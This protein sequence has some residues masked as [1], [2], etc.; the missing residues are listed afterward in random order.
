M[1]KPAAKP[2]PR[3]S[4][5]RAD[6]PSR[7]PPPR[8][9]STAAA[10]GG[11]TC[12]CGPSSQ[13][14]LPARQEVPGSRPPWRISAPRAPISASTPVSSSDPSST[15][16]S[17]FPPKATDGEEGQAAHRGAR[18]SAWKSR[19]RR[20][21]SRAWPSASTRT[22]SSKP[23][24]EGRHA[25]RRPDRRHRLRQECRRLR[26]RMPRGLSA[27]GRP[28]L[29]SPDGS[30]AVP[31][32][33]QSGTAS[34]PASS[35]PTARS[36]ARRWARS[37]SAAPQARRE[38]EK[39]LHPLVLADLR[40]TAAKAAAGGKIRIFVSE[41][42]LIYETGLEEFFDRVV[43][44]RCDKRTQKKRLME[45]DG[46]TAAEA[47]RR[48]KAQMDPAEKARRA[49]YVIVTSGAMEETLARSEAVF[50][51]LLDEVGAQKN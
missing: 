14:R 16:S 11:S 28:G 44:V 3:Q 31:P 13:G 32:G 5:G 19:T 7:L 50:T 21:R 40:A 38:L 20:P 43:V 6:R 9:S 2:K 12:R 45:R 15:W 46:I 10:N 26:L 4:A 36:T 23:S 39:I 49:D 27:P 25:T 42:A 17:R 35:A 34:G 8:R 30:R 29:P 47:D 1:T 41:A 24:P 37:S 18:R 51:L 33:P 48:L 22:S